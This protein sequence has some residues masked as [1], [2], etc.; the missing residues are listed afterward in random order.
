MVKRRDILRR[1]S[2]LMSGIFGVKSVLN[3]VTTSICVL[4][5]KLIALLVAL[6]EKWKVCDFVRLWESRASGNH[7]VSYVMPSRE[8][9][10]SLIPSPNAENSVLT[11]SRSLNLFRRSLTSS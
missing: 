3:S 2:G 4:I 10:E 9:L 7:V 8:S 11:A 1:C 6:I 5:F